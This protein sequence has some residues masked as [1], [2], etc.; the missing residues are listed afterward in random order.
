MRSLCV[1]RRRGTKVYG[2]CAEWLG[3]E[4]FEW[5]MR[6]ILRRNGKKERRS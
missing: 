1:E 6:F 2:I 3:V 5:Y 4:L